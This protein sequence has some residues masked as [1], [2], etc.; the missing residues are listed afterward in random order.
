MQYALIFLI[1]VLQRGFERSASVIPEDHVLRLARVGN[2]VIGSTKQYTEAGR[3]TRVI[4]MK[5]LSTHIEDF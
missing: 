3:I 5:D 4:Q 2:G 1:G